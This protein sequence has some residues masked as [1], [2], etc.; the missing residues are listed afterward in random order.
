MPSART[1]W[2]SCN[3]VLEEK[4]YDA[5][6]QAHRERLEAIQNAASV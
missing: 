5:Q 2:S 3:R 6:L 1:P 4:W